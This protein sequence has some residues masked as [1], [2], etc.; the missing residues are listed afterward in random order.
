MT[1]VLK[2]Q[3]SRAK[4]GVVGGGGCTKGE[5]LG[6]PRLQPCDTQEGHSAACDDKE[7]LHQRDPGQS[8]LKQADALAFSANIAGFL[9]AFCLLFY[10]LFSLLVAGQHID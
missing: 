3:V 8:H 6:A 5:G 4:Q 10:K 9:Q 1:C 2:Q 7:A